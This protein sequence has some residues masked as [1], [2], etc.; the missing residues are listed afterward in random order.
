MLSRVFSP[1][2]HTLYCPK[3]TLKDLLPNGFKQKTVENWR[4]TLK[5]SKR[6]PGRVTRGKKMT[7]FMPRLEYA[8]VYWV[9]QDLYNAFILSRYS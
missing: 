4:Q 6:R 7:L 3:K 5:L 1:G 8:N 2:F 9:V